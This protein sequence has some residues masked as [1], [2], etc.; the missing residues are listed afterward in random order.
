MAA[1]KPQK[2]PKVLSRE[3]VQQLLGRISTRYPTGLRNRVALELMY[4]AGLRVSEVCNLSPTDVDLEQGFITVQQ[5]KGGKDR[6]VPIDP[7]LAEWCRL[8]IEKRQPSEYFLCT[9]KGTKLSDR[10]LRQVCERLSRKAE[11]YLNDNRQQKPVHPHTLRHCFGTE[12][13]EEG[14]TLP[15]VQQ[16]MG[17]ASIQT[18]TIYTHVRPEALAAKIR[19]RGA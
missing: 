4:R 15:E 17:H 18:T 9:H 2:L 14:F 13:V 1:R 8:W 3:Q 5:G 19:Q 10:Y 12:L 7:Q 11:V 16:L 6:V